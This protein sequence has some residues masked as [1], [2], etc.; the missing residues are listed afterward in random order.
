MTRIAL[1]SDTHNTHWA[2]DFPKVDLLI[3]C[4][5]F[6]NLGTKEEFRDFDDWIA[7]LKQQKLIKEAFVVYGNHELLAKK[8]RT[9]ADQILKS[10]DYKVEH[11]CASPF[12]IKIWGCSYIPDCPGWAFNMEEYQLYYIYNQIPVNFDIVV[13]H[14]P[15]QGILDKFLGFQKGSR[16]LAEVLPTK[17]PKIFACGHIHSGRGLKHKNKTLHINCSSV[18]SFYMPLPPIILDI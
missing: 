9:E 7:Y 18:D 17:Q 15:P 16:S 1:L 6:T 8:N 13:C 14:T 10:V 4:G 2:I 12:G 5:D 11:G 3:H